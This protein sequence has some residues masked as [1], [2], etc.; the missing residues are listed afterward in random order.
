MGVLPPTGTEIQMGRV[1]RAYGLGQPGTVTLGLRG[2]LGAQISINSGQIK[3][4]TDFGGRTTP[5]D[6]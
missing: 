6:Y 3:L 4:S 5:F 1:G 2:S